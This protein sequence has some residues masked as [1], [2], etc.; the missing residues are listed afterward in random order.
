MVAHPAPGERGFS[1][2]ATQTRPAV[3]SAGRRSRAMRPFYLAL[4][5]C[6][7]ILVVVAGLLF[8]YEHAGYDLALPGATAIQLGNPLSLRQQQITYRLPRGVSLSDVF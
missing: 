2:S 1:K 7:V 8:V 3:F 4:S 6:M 5:G